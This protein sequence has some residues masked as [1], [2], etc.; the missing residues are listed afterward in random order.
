MHEKD[1]LNKGK[2]E[3]CKKISLY[4]KFYLFGKGCVTANLID[5]YRSMKALHFIEDD[6]LNLRL[7]KR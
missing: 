3:I 2:R 6:D 5:L 7:K 4:L 1:A